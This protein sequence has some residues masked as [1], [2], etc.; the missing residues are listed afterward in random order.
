MFRKDKPPED[1]KQLGPWGER[2]AER[3]LH[4]KGLQILER[5]FRC[6]S[7]EIDL[8]MVDRDRTIVFVEVKT[9]ADETYQ[10]LETAVTYAKKLRMIR[11]ARLFV[12]DHALQDRP[13]RFDVVAIS[14][15]QPRQVRHYPNAFVP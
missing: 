15:A 10:A 1:P 7:G 8:I 13:L 14:L 2:R 4:R 12:A 6:R 9:R 5:N 3:Y 11:A